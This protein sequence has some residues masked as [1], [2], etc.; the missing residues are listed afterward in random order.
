MEGPVVGGQDL[1]GGL[2]RDVAHLL[3]R[4]LKLAAVVDPLAVQR[5]VPPPGS[6]RETVLPF[7][8]QDSW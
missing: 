6:S 3:E 5:G 2:V 7:C 4:G 8:F 1:L